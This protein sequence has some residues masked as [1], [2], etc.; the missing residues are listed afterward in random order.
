VD[1]F[2][3][4]LAQLGVAAAAARRAVDRARDADPAG[5]VGIAAGALPGSGS[6]AELAAVAAG[7][8]EELSRWVQAGTAYAAGLDASAAG[9]TGSE[10]A[11]AR[12][13]G[14]GGPAR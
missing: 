13:Y 3:V 6:A 5:S 8:R 7:W 11:A 1:G 10:A 14:A 4:D 12:G 9:Y 2:E